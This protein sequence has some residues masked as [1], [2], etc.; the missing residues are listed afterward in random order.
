[1]DCKE[2]IALSDASAGLVKRRSSRSSVE[3]L[4]Y[5]SIGTGREWQG[6]V[7]NLSC[8]GC[9]VRKTVPVHRGDILRLLLFPTP[10]R[11]AIEVDHAV[12]RWATLEQFGAEFIM[13]SPRNT[14]RL[15]DYLAVFEE[16]F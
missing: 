11:S 6:T 16:G 13:L 10:N 3:F 14:K 15:S 7:L 9:A 4:C 5:Y 8:D 1:M 12:V 2:S